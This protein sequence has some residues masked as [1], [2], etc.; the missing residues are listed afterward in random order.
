MERTYGPVVR[1]MTG[2]TT[3]VLV[4][5]WRGFDVEIVAQHRKE[6]NVEDDV[7]MEIYTIPV[8]LPR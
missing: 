1:E 2:M 4:K 6:G 5:L 8:G 3:R 7:I